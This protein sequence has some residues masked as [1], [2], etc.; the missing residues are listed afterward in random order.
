[1]K[2]SALARSLHSSPTL[3][4]SAKARAMKARGIDVI[5]LSAGELDF[6]PPDVVVE[7]AEKSIEAGNI[8]YTAAI[9]MPKLRESVAKRY[10]Q[11]YNASIDAQNIAITVG[12]KQALANTLLALIEP[13]DEVI[14]PAPYWVSYPEMVEL[15][16]GKA[17]FVETTAG[18]NFHLEPEKFENAISEKTRILMLN[19]PSNPTGAVYSESELT[20]IFEI[21]KRHNI[22]IL[23]DEIYEDLILDGEFFSFI[24][25]HENIF[26]NVVVI[27]GISKTFAMTGWRIGWAI[28]APELISAL[29]RIQGHQTSNSC[30]ISQYA[31]IAALE[32]A[33]DFAPKIVREIRKRRDVA[34]EMLSQIPGFKPVKPAGA[35]YIFCDVK[36]ALGKKFSSSAK[37]SEFLLENAHVAAVPGEAFGIEGYLRIS[38]AA[39]M[40]NIAEAITRIKN[41]I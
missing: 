28:A 12:A 32:K 20:E 41:T 40:K 11:K 1:M 17:V 6:S 29:G 14:I 21:A 26:D 31:A 24:Q 27:S 38:I 36:D 10:S 7:A 33:N 37:L 18:K 19:S 23:A 34:I 8:K 3:S 16:R 35:F 30:T 5:A 4:L 22:I 15:A 13:G 9:G 25:F 2:I 39:S